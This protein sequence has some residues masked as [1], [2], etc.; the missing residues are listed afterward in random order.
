MVFSNIKDY[1][2]QVGSTNTQLKYG[3]VSTD[4]DE[5]EDCPIGAH[6][7]EGLVDGITMDETGVLTFATTTK[8]P[9]TTIKI[10]VTVGSQQIVSEPFTFEIIDCQ[11]F[12]KFPALEDVYVQVDSEVS[13]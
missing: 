6:T 9:R 13:L 4:D 5:H 11:E 8:I 2:A 10:T 3:A 12:V 7:V 1:V